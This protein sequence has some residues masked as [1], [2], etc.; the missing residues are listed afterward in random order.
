MY[1]VDESELFWRALPSKTDVSHDEKTAPG[2]KVR[3]E[4]VTMLP[5]VN[6]SGTHRLTMVVIGKA[7]KLRV[8]ENI[9]L[10]VHYYGQ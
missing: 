2:R 5:R 9:D 1:K 4:P 7:K 6:A 8:F 3:K 10:P